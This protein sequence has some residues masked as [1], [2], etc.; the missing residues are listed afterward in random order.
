MKHK[1]LLA[2][3]LIAAAIGLPAA[4]LAAPITYTFAGI[5]T[6]D[7]Y[8]VLGSDTSFSGIYTFESTAPDL[9]A[10]PSTGVYA[11]NGAGFGFQALVGG[12]NYS[13]F[14]SLS[15]NVA[16]NFAGPVDQYGVF[17]S[18]G[19]LSLELFFQDNDANVFNNDALP[20]NS[21]SLAT[22]ESAQFRL[23]GD[24][25]E[26]LGSTNMFGCIAGC[27]GDANP[28]PDLPPTSVP[29]PGAA[30]L[31]LTGLAFMGFARRRHKEPALCA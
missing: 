14:G 28:D 24:G 26:F 12:T 20:L 27:D 11:S 5:L 15:V 4:A 6:D 3:I 18:D 8:G 7:P 25:V 21:L 31:L 13:I 2:T 9:V 23:F 30:L 22:F 1:H 17:A 19:S 10:D 29:E 16:N